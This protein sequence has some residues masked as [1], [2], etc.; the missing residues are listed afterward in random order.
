VDK[1]VTAE[2][3]AGPAQPTGVRPHRGPPRQGRRSTD[4]PP[5]RTLSALGPVGPGQPFSTVVLVLV[6]V[7]LVSP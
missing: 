7:G 4:E 2:G 1:S 3:D 5:Y 6:L